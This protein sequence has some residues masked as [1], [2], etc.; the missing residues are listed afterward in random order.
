MLLWA[1]WITSL[2]CVYLWGL[3]YRGLFSVK[4]CRASRSWRLTLSSRRN[5]R[6][7]DR[8]KSCRDVSV[9]LAKQHVSVPTWGSIAS[10]KSSC[11]LQGKCESCYYNLCVHAVFVQWRIATET[12][13]MRVTRGLQS[14]APMT[15]KWSVSISNFSSASTPYQWGACMH[16]CVCVIFSPSGAGPWCWEG[17]LQDSVAAEEEGPKDLRER[18]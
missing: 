10:F 4:T 12:E 6:S 13:Q 11:F 14:P 9:S 17:F 1:T 15:V 5:M 18:C 8:K 16:N 7:I 3:N 2:G